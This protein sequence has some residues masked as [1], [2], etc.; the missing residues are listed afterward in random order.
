[1]VCLPRDNLTTGRGDALLLPQDFG[2]KRGE[3]DMKT[4][5]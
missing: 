2:R 5:L 4:N 3:A 1:M